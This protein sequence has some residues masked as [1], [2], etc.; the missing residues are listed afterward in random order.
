MS[1][2]AEGL[3]TFDVLYYPLINPPIAAWFSAAMLYFD[4][5]GIIVPENFDS[6][7]VYVSSRTR[8]LIDSKLVE[9]IS[10]VSHYRWNAVSDEKFFG[11][12]EGNDGLLSSI[13]RDRDAGRTE[14]VHVGKVSRSNVFWGC[15]QRGWVR[16]QADEWHQ[17]PHSLAGFLMTYIA[18]IM[19][20]SGSMNMITDFQQ[21]Y[22]M[23]ER[24]GRYCFRDGGRGG[25]AKVAVRGMILEKILSVPR[26][27]DPM[28]LKEIREKHRLLF[29]SFRR[30]IEGVVE[31]ILESE[32]EDDL[33]SN[34]DAHVREMSDHR[35]EIAR[36]I[37]EGGI[38]DVSS[39]S[40]TMAS[41][42]IA[43]ALID[44][45][46]VNIFS[47]FASVLATVYDEGRRVHRGW[48]AKQDPLAFAVL[49]EGRFRKPL[50]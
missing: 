5:V 11:F 25:D 24:I 46:P 9:P 13:V 44:R 4:R 43:A 29:T 16:E 15:I 42:P 6:N 8:R 45:S 38:G 10:A 7:S 40:L 17:V 35:K 32:D 28:V 14:R 26:H 37:Q 18:A 34:I 48:Q 33:E 50:Q 22:A 3:S 23:T 36:R 20:S 1:Q 41:I 49:A 19:A 30:H 12:V 47:A 27:A 2:H 39:H 21:D 31:K